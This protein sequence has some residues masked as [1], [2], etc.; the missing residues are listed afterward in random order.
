MGS[1][2]SVIEEYF[3]STA[4]KDQPLTEVLFAETRVG[5]L[6]IVIVSKDRLAHGP[7]IAE[8]EVE[9]LLAERGVINIPEDRPPVSERPK[10]S[11]VSGKPVS[12]TIIEERR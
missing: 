7:D 10:P 9:R 2:K 4:S 6:D 11:H 12:E 1:A 8:D 3:I 5:D